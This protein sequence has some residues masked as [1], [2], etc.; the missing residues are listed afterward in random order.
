MIIYP[1][2]ER[3]LLK[4]LSCGEF[5]PESGNGHLPKAW[6]CSLGGFVLRRLRTK[7]SRWSFTECTI[8]FFKGP[9]LWQIYMI[10][11]WWS[12]THSAWSCSLKG[13]VPCQLHTAMS[14]RYFHQMYDCVLLKAMSRGI[15]SNEDQ[16]V[17][18]TCRV[19]I[20]LSIFIDTVIITTKI[21]VLQPRK[22]NSHTEFRVQSDV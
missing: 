12:F 19:S 2:Y 3:V 18:R 13:P 15:V 11:F 14:R 21:L 17:W 22:R 4:D 16:D 10:I 9:V 7:N 5:I 20:L 8:L 6:A 1:M